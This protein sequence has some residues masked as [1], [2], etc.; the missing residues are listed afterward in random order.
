MKF[1]ATTRAGRRPRAQEQEQ[2]RRRREKK[3]FELPEERLEEGEDQNEE[4]RE[5]VGEEGE[6]AEEARGG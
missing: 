4:K 5:I 1:L 2:K 6:D 3:I